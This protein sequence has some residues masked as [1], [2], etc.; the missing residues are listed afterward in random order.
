MVVETSIRSAGSRSKKTSLF[1]GDSDKCREQEYGGKIVRNSGNVEEIAFGRAR[2]P[3]KMTLGAVMEV[4]RL[5]ILALSEFR[6]SGGGLRRLCRR[7]SS[8]WSR[9]HHEGANGT[10]SR[11][12]MLKQYGDK[13][14]SNRA[15]CMAPVASNDHDGVQIWVR[16]SR[17][18]LEKQ[19]KMRYP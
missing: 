16:M 18:A 9:A 8:R 12:R 4:V 10:W 13:S 7:G 5:I 6:D 2:S 19:V 3:W 11:T 14:I 17:A 1:K 15:V